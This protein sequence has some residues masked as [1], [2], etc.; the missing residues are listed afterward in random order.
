MAYQHYLFGKLIE[1]QDPLSPAQAREILD[2]A[3]ALRRR[4][5]ELPIDSIV[6]I[7]DRVGQKWADPG[8]PPRKRVLEV[9]PD[10]VGFDPAMA[11][12]ALDALAGNMGRPTLELLISHQLGSAAHLDRWVY[13]HA[14][15]GYLMAQPL[16]VVLHVSP[17]N[18]FVGGADS[19]ITGL[20]TKNVNLLKVAGADPVFPL[21]FAH[22]IREV[23]T[24]GLLADMFCVLNFRGGEHQLEDC[25]KTGCD[26]IVV[27]GSA[28]TVA[29]YQDGLGPQTRL[30]EHGHRLGFSMI[31]SAGAARKGLEATAQAMARDIVMWEQRACAS[32]QRIF[33]EADLAE[34]LGE[35]LARALEAECRA[36]PRGRLSVDEQV[37]IIRA[38]ELARADQ[39]AGDGRMWASAP[40]TDWTVILE[41]PG[42]PFTPSP[43]NRCIHLSPYR[44]WEEVES[45]L[46]PF[47]SYLQ[48]AGV[49]AD[50]RQ[51]RVISRNLAR[52]GVTRITRVGSMHSGK[53]AAP[54][55]GAFSLEQLIRWVCVEDVEER[56]DLD[57]V[58]VD[59]LAPEETWERLRSQVEFARHNSPFYMER[60][61]GFALDSPADLAA[62]P[63]LTG[64]DFHQHSPPQG[65]GL[66]TAPV[67]DAYIF[68]TGGSTGSPKASLYTY[69][70]FDRV[71]D[72]LSEIY[73]LG[74]I[75]RRDSAANLFMAGNLWT[76]FIVADKALEK[77]GCINLPIAGN[78]D[79]DLLL[80]Y[81][82]LFRPTVL[83][84]L[85]SIIIKLASEIVRR[86][87][88]NLN[89]STILYGGE[90]M[91]EE[92]RAFLV[93][94]LGVKRV[95]SAGYASVDAGVIGFQCAQCTGSIHHL[96]GGY[97]YLE[98]LDP[99][100]GRP[101]PRGEPGEIV[102]T[103]LQ[104]RLMPLIRYRTGDRGRELEGV[105]ACGRKGLRFELL[106][107]CD[108][109]VRV[110]SVSL[111]PEDL[112]EILGRFPEL[113]PLFQVEASREGT[114]DVV[115]VWVEEMAP[116]ADREGLARRLAEVMIMEREELAE[117]L[118]RGWLGRLEVR[119]VPA[120]T[121]PRVERTGKIR[122][123]VDRR[124]PDL[125]TAVDHLRE[126]D[127]H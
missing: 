74:G 30:V 60:L 13:H 38:R 37:E 8:Y 113:S 116:P 64:R 115:T 31:T 43:L 10:A 45:A 48:S 55:D 72:L 88:R 86:D 56:F 27:W 19:L 109:C 127:A 77:I 20:I 103:G 22:S 101:V 118:N 76:S 106:G 9:L 97:Q 99:D 126:G 68:C 1:K 40:G 12:L 66:L 69:A 120:G 70:E 32:P 83:L 35:S 5:Q 16:G 84:G 75:S 14:V 62:F 121:I 39:A 34:S 95:S 63:T 61:A 79:P 119:P 25:F 59:D 11:A 78:A 53:E 96:L 29:S 21:L 52:A 3:R 123:F 44:N 4:I 49:L 87:I 114:R 73:R 110:G 91:G 107:R 90:H 41:P 28:T 117:A 98:L 54:H 100:S 42:R 81:I 104:R 2:Q 51:M 50:P 122:R 6:S 7:L 58:L 94:S 15:E 57:S 105:C 93:E 89:I 23:D 102:V 67:G 85:P 36:L 112:E 24:E 47:S 111:Y 71:T 17:G 124:I 33:V 125:P 108:D 80:R 65:E 26:G 92:A 46:K 18:V 82:L